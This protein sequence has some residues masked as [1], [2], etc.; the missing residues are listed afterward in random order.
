M[1][2]WPQHLQHVLKKGLVR[3]TPLHLLH[4]QIICHKIVFQTLTKTG[5]WPVPAYGGVCGRLE[6]VAHEGEP[7]STF[8]HV[9]WHRKLK[10]AKKILE[11]AMDFTFKHDR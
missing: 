1:A 10:F 9:S 3:V 8:T 11:A 6:V 5:G 7:L 2:R 4:F